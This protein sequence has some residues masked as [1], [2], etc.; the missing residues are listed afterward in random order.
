MALSLAALLLYPAAVSL[1]VLE[2]ER[3]GVFHETSVIDGTGS[4]WRDGHPWLALIVVT[5]S[6][7]I[8]LA[9][10]L[11]LFVLSSGI[12]RISAP[13]GRRLWGS[14]D[15]LGRWGMLDVLLVAVLVAVVKLGELVRIE[16][17]PGAALFAAMVVCSLIASAVFDPRILRQEF[18]T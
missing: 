9:K 14:I 16:P 1:P 4:L 17:G 6:V 2:I 11:G 5:C 8:P 15:G 13:I 10:I 12:V 7:V 3:F 18:A